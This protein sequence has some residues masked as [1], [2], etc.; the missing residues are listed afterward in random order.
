MDQAGRPAMSLYSGAIEARRNPKNG[1]A[2]DI[3]KEEG[4]DGE[5]EEGEDGEE[6]EE[7]AAGSDSASPFRLK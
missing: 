7:A 5:E 2:D 3:V 6:E 4:D 1:A